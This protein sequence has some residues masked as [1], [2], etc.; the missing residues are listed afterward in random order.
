MPR[1]TILIPKEALLLP[2][3]HVFAKLDYFITC[4]LD[5][6]FNLRPALEFEGIMQVAKRC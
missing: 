4:K 5:E 6:I 1:V 2:I 3:L